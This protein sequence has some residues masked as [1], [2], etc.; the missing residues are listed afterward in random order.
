MYVYQSLESIE[1]AQDRLDKA[2]L[3]GEV[4]EGEY[5]TSCWA[6]ER[7][8]REIEQRRKRR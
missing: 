1:R 5:E 8:E 4:T 2:Y 3:K 7:A 6:L